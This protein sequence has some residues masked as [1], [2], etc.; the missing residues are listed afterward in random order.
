MAKPE[1]KEEVFEVKEPVVG[2]A[3]VA[4]QASLALINLCSSGMTVAEAKKK[5]GIK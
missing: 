2:V 5:L 3:P 4:E 1:K